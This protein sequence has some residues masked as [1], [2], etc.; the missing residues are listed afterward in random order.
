[1]EYDVYISLRKVILVDRLASSW[2]RR[3]VLLL[4]DTEAKRRGWIQIQS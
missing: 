1:M 3:V 2:Q 4:A